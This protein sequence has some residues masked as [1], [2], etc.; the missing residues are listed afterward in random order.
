LA[1]HELSHHIFVVGGSQVV[2]E[3]VVEL[4][5]VPGGVFGIDTHLRRRQLD[6]IVEHPEV[7]GKTQGL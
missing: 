3:L 1:D 7:L 2:G 5:E 6:D 4:L